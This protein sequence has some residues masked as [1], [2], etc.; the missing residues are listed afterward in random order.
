MQIVIPMSGFGDRF[1][2]A[3]YTIPKPLIEV[4][5]KPIIGHVIDLFPGEKE[6]IF[7]CNEEHLS[8]PQYR[9]G[10]I[11]IRLCPSGR[12]VGISPHKLGRGKAKAE[13]IQVKSSKA[14]NEVCNK[15]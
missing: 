2:R 4:D 13:F 14:K 1:R 7:I 9:M 6:F 3:G 12:I 11:L 15:Q 8:D 10:E 5:G